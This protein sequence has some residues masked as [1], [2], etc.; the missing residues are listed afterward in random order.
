MP[1]GGSGSRQRMR[2]ASRARKRVVT[3]NMTL[4][5]LNRPGINKSLVRTMTE[6]EKRKT[7]MRPSKGKPWTSPPAP[8]SS[9]RSSK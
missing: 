4:S 9:A 1:S 8:A 5:D 2:R 7:E 3:F 6:A